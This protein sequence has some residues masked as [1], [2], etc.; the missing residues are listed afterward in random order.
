M[1]YFNFTRNAT[2]QTIQSSLYIYIYI[3]KYPSTCNPQP[4]S[5]M[6]EHSRLISKCLRYLS[7]FFFPSGRNWK[8]GRE[9]IR[10]KGFAIPIWV[11]RK[12]ILWGGKHSVYVDHPGSC[13]HAFAHRSQ[14][15]E[16]GSG[17]SVCKVFVFKWN[18]SILCKEEIEK[19]NNIQEKETKFTQNW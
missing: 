3:E 2:L 5:R 18:S 17:A 13:F 10:K 19:E 1:L 8:D 9:R 6:V 7:P 4:G 11:F 14:I 15:K 16:L 12:R